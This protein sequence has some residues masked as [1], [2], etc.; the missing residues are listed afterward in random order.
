MEA[1]K[2]KSIAVKTAKIVGISSVTILALL[3]VT[4]LIFSDIIKE[5]I[6][7]TA[8]KKL[9]GEMNYSD[10]SVSFFKHFP[11]LTITLNDFSLIGSAPFQ[12]ENLIKELKSFMEVM[13]QL[14][15]EYNK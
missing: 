14:E 10:A 3:F 15:N 5:E 8:N 12:K 13:V 7:K 11:S 1:G 2:I 9:S 4:P 6:K